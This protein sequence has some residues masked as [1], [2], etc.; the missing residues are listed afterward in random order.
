M[1]TTDRV[2]RAVELG[3][4]GCACSEAVLLAYG[5]EC[6]L[7]PDSALRLASGLAGGVGRSGGVCG[8]LSAAVLV[9]GLRLGP[10]NLA[11]RAGRVRSMDAAGELLER[12]A[13][14]HGSTDCCDL[15]ATAMAGTDIT[16]LKGAQALRLSGWPE[17]MVRSAA[18]CLQAVL[19]QRAGPG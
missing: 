12:F 1:H 13:A 17:Q 3:T 4:Q 2:E 16:T 7:A 15:C 11:D 5:V 10:E 18:E 14:L 19:D 9:L 6:G 8:A